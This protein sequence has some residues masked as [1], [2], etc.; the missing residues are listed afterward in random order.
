HL[1]PEAGTDR[2]RLANFSHDFLRPNW[3]FNLHPPAGEPSKLA[4]RPEGTRACRLLHLFEY[5]AGKLSPV[6]GEKAVGLSGD[7]GKAPCRGTADDGAGRRPT[8]G[9]GSRVGD[10]PGRR[11][12]RCRNLAT[13]YEDKSVRHGIV[14]Q[15]RN[16]T[17]SAS[18]NI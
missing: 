5:G 4:Y 8:D 6:D 16:A 12:T 11:R 13:A 18:R 7:G 15:R 10:T 1:S 17:A 2:T 14:G 3:L 9:D